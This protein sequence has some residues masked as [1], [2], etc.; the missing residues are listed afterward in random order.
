V[1]EVVPPRPDERTHEVICLY[2]GYWL[3]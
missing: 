1:Q 2:H 3:F